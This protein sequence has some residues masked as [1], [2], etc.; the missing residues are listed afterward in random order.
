MKTVTRLVP[1]NLTFF[2]ELRGAT[3]MDLANALEVSRQ[4]VSN[5]ESGQ[6][7]PDFWTVKRLAAFLK[8]PYSL[9]VTEQQQLSEGNLT[10]FR[11]KVAV[12]KRLMTSYDH[13][14]KIYGALVSE[15]SQLVKFPD[16]I[17]DSIISKDT[18]FKILSEEY[19][20]D[21]ARKVRDHFGMQ[22]GPIS[23]VTA[24]LER[25][26]I[27]VAFVEQSGTGINALTKEINGNFLVML[28]IADQSAVRIRFSLAHELGHI[29]LHSHYSESSY[30]SKEMHKRLEAEANMFASSLLMPREGFLLDVIRPT[31]G[32]LLALKPHWKVAIQAMAVRLK[33]LCIIDNQQEVQIFK[34]ISRKYSRKNEPYDFGLNSIDVEYPTL[35][36]SAIEYLEDNHID[37]K[38]VI[39]K[40]GYSVSFLKE[41]FPFLSFSNN[42]SDDD[43][44]QPN[45][46]LM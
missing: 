37:Y 38:Y 9:L 22:D 14:L 7:S 10:L 34:E 39:R 35:M 21:T 2:R 33:Q 28:N 23:N 30:K 36:N 31:F 15:L 41:T 13:Q 8:I 1:H 27:H 6:R 29:L 18:T 24:L 25:A 26:G 16:F 40:H 12:P 3:I 20:E 4:A 19:I 46:H 43:D 17:L 11:S 44:K 42:V 5:W 32:G 45:L